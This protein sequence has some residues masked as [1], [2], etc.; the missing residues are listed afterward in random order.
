[1]GEITRTNVE[2]GETRNILTYPQM[3]VGLAPRDL[4]YRFNW[5]APIRISRHNPNILYHASQVIHRS[6]NEGQS[7]EV[8]SPDLSRDDKSKE[9]YSGAPITYENT[10]VEVYANVLSFEESPVSAGLLWAGSDDG[11]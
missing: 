9:D 3:E 5:N 1:G 8:V 2:T 10:G 7:W 4:R 6:M 11:L